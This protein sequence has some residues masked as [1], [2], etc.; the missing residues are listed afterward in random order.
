MSSNLYQSLAWLPRTPSDFS[1]RC[2]TLLDT[3][4][5]LGSR[6]QALAN[7]AL[8][9][10]QLHRLAQ[11]IQAARAKQFSLKPLAPFRLGILSNATTDFVV[12]ALTAT[13]ARHG[14]DL[15]V[16]AS[17][18]GQVMQEALSADSAINRA[19]PDAVLIALDYRGLVL[20]TPKS[21]WHRSRPSAKGFTRATTQCVSSRISPRPQKSCSAASMPP[22][23]EACATR[24][25]R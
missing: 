13:A 12:P 5:N 4:D 15:Q 20:R 21:R 18:Y 11:L 8:D 3:G 10:N 14:I 24:S 1:S 25:T 2:R 19:E 6:I 16:V 7:H 23:P 17:A 9:E 22:F